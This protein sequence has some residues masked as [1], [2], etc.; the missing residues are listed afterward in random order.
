[1]AQKASNDRIS[2]SLFGL[3]A[4]AEGVKGIAA[5]LAVAS[6]LFAARWMG[7]L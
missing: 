5:F 3:K 2:V 4:E 6:L 1:V 7:L